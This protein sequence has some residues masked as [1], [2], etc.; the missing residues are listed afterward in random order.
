MVQSLLERI[1]VQLLLL[2]Q[3]LCPHYFAIT[4]T[5]SVKLTV[6]ISHISNDFVAIAAALAGC[7]QLHHTAVEVYM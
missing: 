3:R 6:T 5:E 2:E 7:C 4:A 1:Y